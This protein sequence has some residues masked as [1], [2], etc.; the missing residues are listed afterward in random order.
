MAK[1][2]KGGPQKECPKC[3]ASVHAR[4]KACSC[5][6]EFEFKVKTDKVK[7]VKTQSSLVDLHTALPII[8]AMGGVKA[9]QTAIDAIRKAESTVDKLGGVEK[10]EA[11]LKEIE[12]LRTV[13]GK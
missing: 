1:K 13:L 2:A 10:A 3:K 5:G 11:L 4:S 6:Y 9:L 8:Q 12:T 7:T